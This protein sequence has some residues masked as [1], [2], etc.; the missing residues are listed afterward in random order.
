[1]YAEYT[2]PQLTFLALLPWFL[3]NNIPVKPLYYNGDYPSNNLE[4]IVVF[5]SRRR[6]LNSDNFLNCLCGFNRFYTGKLQL[7]S[8]SSLM[9]QRIKGY[10]IVK[11]EH[12]GGW[13]GGSSPSQTIVNRI[14]HSIN[15]G[16]LKIM[17]LLT[18]FYLNPLFNEI[19]R[20]C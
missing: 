9:R 6:L 16:L 1:M 14:G 19:N 8:H 15:R 5:Y 3:V 13:Q 7:K 2:Q 20:I 10:T 11:G 17:S 18:S 4:F 12:R